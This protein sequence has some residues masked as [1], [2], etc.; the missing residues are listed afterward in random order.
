L[1]E[2]KKVDIDYEYVM[3]RVERKSFMERTSLVLSFMPHTIH[4][5]R[6]AEYNLSSS[7][8]RDRAKAE[9]TRLAYT[10]GA[11][12]QYELKGH[13]FFETGL[14]YTQIYEEMSFEGKK[15]FSNQYNFVEVPLLFGFQN[16]N[17]KWGWH[18][19]GGLG[20]QVYN[21]YQGYTLKR[22]DVFGG[23]EPEPLY[24]ANGQTIR[25]F[26][27]ND[28]RLT[29]NQAKNEVVSL[30]NDAEHPYRTSGVVNVHLATGVTY[31]HS[32][33]TSFLITPTY[34]RSVNSITK[35]SALFSEKINYMGVSFGARVK[36]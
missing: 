35:E 6:R 25:N 4:K 27:A 23:E 14:N 10:V 30:E 34:K 16:R 2:P 9:E 28:H 15:R 21:T 3:P 20:V 1:M 24:R 19:K 8:L 22:V 5:S 36:F 29:N 32:I 7:F 18:V 17:S 13:K 12:L 11:L 26:I 33:K 31:Y